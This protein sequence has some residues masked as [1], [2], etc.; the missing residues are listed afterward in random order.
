[1]SLP[2]QADEF[3]SRMADL[4]L[5]ELNSNSNYCRSNNGTLRQ[6][7]SERFN[8]ARTYYRT[9]IVRTCVMK[10]F[11]H[12]YALTVTLQRIFYSTLASPDRY[13]R[14]HNRTS[15]CFFR[16]IIIDHNQAVRTT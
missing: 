4:A 8:D 10:P 15:E 13:C 2:I 14:G 1:M 11:E 16:V 9:C 7:S 6:K 12:A 5:V 3:Q